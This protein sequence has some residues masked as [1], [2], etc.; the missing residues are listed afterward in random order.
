MSSG[1][2]GV[3]RGS[4]QLSESIGQKPL[5][6]ITLVELMLVIL[7]TWV[8]ISFWDRAAAVFVF[9]NLG[10]KKSS[11]FQIL[12]MALAATA[13]LIAFTYIPNVVVNETVTGIYA[14]QQ[15]EKR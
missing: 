10:I 1:L 8:V 14:G 7:F 2:I 13:I 11:A 5:A 4:E 9:G 15:F 6:E 12:I 3:L